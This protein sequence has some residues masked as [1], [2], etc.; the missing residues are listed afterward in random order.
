[1]K[2]VVATD[3]TSA[4]IDAAHR[5][6]ELLRPGAE[7]VLV[8]AI[9]DWEDPMASAGGFEGPVESDDEADEEYAERVASG[10]AALERTASAISE[11]IETRLITADED[12]GHAIVHF[13]E[14]LRPDVI[15]IGAGGKSALKRL[16]LGSVSDHVVHHAPC[17]V[18][19]VH[20]HD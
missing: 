2:V 5:A 6:I 16:L 14:Q 15:V 1:M 10:T 13:A 18:L 11:R 4:A 19:V 12:P 7:I 20:H 8:T 9:R 3:G 17:P